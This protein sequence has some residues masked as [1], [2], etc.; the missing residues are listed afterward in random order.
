MTQT[1]R[2]DDV[3]E[4]VIMESAIAPSTTEHR[5]PSDCP[6]EIKAQDPD[7]APWLEGIQQSSDDRRF[8][9]ILFNSSCPGAETDKAIH[10]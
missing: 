10:P 1:V 6:T 7:A 8:E 2:R 9:A 5:V 4:T 3:S